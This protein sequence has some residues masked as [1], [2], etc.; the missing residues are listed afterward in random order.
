M[1]S[2]WGLGDCMGK[3]CGTTSHDCPRHG[4]CL[5]GPLYRC[6]AV[7]HGKLLAA[8]NQREAHVFP[9]AA[10]LVLSQ[11]PRQSQCLL[12]ASEPY[13]AAPPGRQLAVTE[14]VGKGRVPS[15]PRL[16][17]MLGRRPGAGGNSRA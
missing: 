2:E 7:A 8:Q 3:P 13:F 16:R 6:T 14:V 15:L 17:A 12:R 11:F 5:A 1:G 10:A 9:V 4:I